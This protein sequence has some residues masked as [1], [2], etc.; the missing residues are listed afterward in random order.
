LTKLDTWR[1]FKSLLTIDKDLTQLKVLDYSDGALLMDVGSAT[2]F[3]W[4]EDSYSVAQAVNKERN[5]YPFCFS[6]HTTATSLNEIE[7]KYGNW[8]LVQDNIALKPT[9]ETFSDLTWEEIM[10]KMFGK[11]TSTSNFYVKLL[12]LMASKEGILNIFPMN[13]F[14]IIPSEVIQS[15]GKYFVRGDCILNKSRTLLQE[16]HELKDMIS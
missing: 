12:D 8:R 4:Q 13:K 7:S 3:V 6:V 10:Q 2:L 16:W 14:H 5:A 11:P 9:N 15:H 1:G